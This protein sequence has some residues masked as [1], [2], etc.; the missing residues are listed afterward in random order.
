MVTTSPNKNH[1]GLFGNGDGET[2]LKRRA[3]IR[4]NEATT[5]PST[6]EREVV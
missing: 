2:F 6:I 3:R 4:Y 1:F 5:L